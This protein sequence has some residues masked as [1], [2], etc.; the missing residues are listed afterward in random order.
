MRH[1]LHQPRVDEDARRDGIE[2]AVDDQCV[3]TA[4]RVRGPDAQ[5]RRQRYRRR[6]GVRERED[7]GRRA[8]GFGPRG[9]GEAGA[10]AEALEGLVEDEDDVE[11]CEFLAGDGE[12]EADEDGVEDDAELEDEDGRHLRGVVLDPAA[13]VRVRGFRVV[14]VVVAAVVVVVAHVL[15]TVTEVVFA[16]GVAGGTAGFAR[17]L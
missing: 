5:A 15:A 2:H 8:L 14:V 12:G 17:E 6:Q 4:G 10:E 3:R 7:V 11:G 13:A 1:Q 9:G 16:G